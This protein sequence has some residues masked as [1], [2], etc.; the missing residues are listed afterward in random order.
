M[1]TYGN[2]ITIKHPSFGANVDFQRG[3]KIVEDGVNKNNRRVT[4]DDIVVKNINL[5][6]AHVKIYPCRSCTLPTVVNVNTFYVFLSIRDPLFLFLLHYVSYL[7]KKKRPS[8]T[9]GGHPARVN[10]CT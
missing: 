10:A 4:S 9:L 5:N 8:N 7:T 6:N 1:W 3:S 2:S